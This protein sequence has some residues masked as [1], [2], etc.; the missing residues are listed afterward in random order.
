MI[1]LL[2]NKSNAF[3]AYK[4]FVAWVET[5]LMKK[6]KILHSDRGGEYLSK[7]FTSFLNKKGTER[8]LTVHDMPE[9]N[10][11]AER[12]NRTLVERVRAMLIGT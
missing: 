5:Q 7:E 3:D 1:Y 9:E 12:L 10:G 4:T 11:V 8:K 2:T 6:I